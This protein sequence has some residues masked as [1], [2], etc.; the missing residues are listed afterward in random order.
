MKS[1]VRR[2]QRCKRAVI[3]LTGLILLSGCDLIARIP[4][5]QIHKQKGGV[6]KVEVEV[7]R[8]PAERNLG[9]MFRKSLDKDK[10][11]LFIFEKEN[12]QTFIMKN[13]FIPLD[14]IFISSDMR[15]AGWVENA[16]PLSQEQF[17]IARP[18]QYVLEV[19]AFFCRDKGLSV[20]DE[21]TFKNVD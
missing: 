3:A 1:P 20:G 2:S 17:S 16:K 13:T 19:N 7:A 11:M 4:A 10:G 5:V 14:M 18:S 8:K 15:V 6:V 9:F 12:K 21:I